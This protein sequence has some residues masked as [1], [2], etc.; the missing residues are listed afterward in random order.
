MLE[1]H[2]IFHPA[3]FP[4]QTY[5]TASYLAAILCRPR[6]RCSPCIFHSPHDVPEVN[7]GCLSLARGIDCWCGSKDKEAPSKQSISVQRE[8]QN[9]TPR[10]AVSPKKAHPCEMCGLIFG[11]V[12]HFVDHQ[13]THQKQKLNGSGACGK[14]LDDTANLNQHQKQHIGEKFC[15]K[16]IRE[17]SFVKKRK[18]RV[19]QEPFVFHEFGEN[20]LPSSGLC[21]QEASYPVEKTDSETKHGPPFQEGKTNSGCGKRTKAFSTKH[22]VIP[23]QKLFTRDGCYVCSDCGKSFSRYVSFSKHQRDHTEKGPYECGECGKSYSQKS[24]LIQHQQ[25]HTGKTAY[26]CG[27]CEKSFS[28]KDS[29]NHQHVHTGEGPYEC[30][31]CGKSFGQ[32]GKFIQHQRGHTGETAYHCGECGKSFRQKFCF[33][34]HQHVHTGERPYKCGECGKSFGQKGNLIQHQRGHTGECKECGKLFR[35]RSHLTEHQRLHTGERPY[36]C[37]ECGKLF[38]RKYHLLVHERVHTG[39]RLYECEVCGKLFGNK[40]SMTIH[41]RIHTGERP[42]EC[43][44]FTLE[45][46]LMNAPNVEKEFSE[47][48]PS[49]I[50][51]HTGERPYECSECGKSFTETSSLIKHRRVHTGERT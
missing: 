37:R 19:S 2:G 24:S 1:L 11:D 3:V 40:H 18:L 27:E 35:Y 17:A 32:K 50:R 43:R 41:Q 26:P 36:N 15:R 30:G 4:C 22:S 7:F 25:V 6:G 51:V 14:N 42:Y 47:A 33:I 44:E 46:G 16:S 23:H 5:V 31:E 10:A 29:L 28:Q 20:V 38:N 34:N 13:E 8:S 39:E 12:F 45:K 49:I 21:Q 48:L 9:T